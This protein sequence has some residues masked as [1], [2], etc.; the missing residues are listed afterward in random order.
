MVSYQSA[1]SVSSVYPGPTP[2]GP[3]FS[4]DLIGPRGVIFG[5]VDHAYGLA[6][7][8]Q[9]NWS[10]LA[11]MDSI[12]DSPPAAG[13]PKKFLGTAHGP[14]LRPGPLAPAQPKK[15]HFL[16]PFLGYFAHFWVIL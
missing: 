10:G 7:C 2:L 16:G 11:Q 13:G 5:S 4:R 6:H 15:K 3:N 14:I 9:Q 12:W 8:F 1:V